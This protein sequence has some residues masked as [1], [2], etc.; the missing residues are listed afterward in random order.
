MKETGKPNENRRLKR[1][2]AENFSGNAEMGGGTSWIFRISGIIFFVATLITVVEMLQVNTSSFMF[3]MKNE[4]SAWNL[5]FILTA[6][7]Y[8]TSFINAVLATGTAAIFGGRNNY[9]Q[10]VWNCQMFS[11]VCLSLYASA[12][13]LTGY[14]GNN[15]EEAE[16]MFILATSL[17]MEIFF[18]V[19]SF[20]CLREVPMFK[21][22]DI[23]PK[24]Q[25]SKL[26]MKVYILMLA[27][28]EAGCFLYAN[29]MLNR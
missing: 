1:N 12:Q 20:F 11:I 2:S 14:D 24:D 19:I 27:L 28:I 21:W 7:L 4:P 9:T 3:I 16:T 8:T 10:S 13:I 5:F 25:N 26:C 18:A 23:R 6:V 29:R 17:V 22:R 15:P